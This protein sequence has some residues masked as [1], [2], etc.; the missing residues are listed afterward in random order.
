MTTTRR[1][2]P[3]DPGRR[4]MT[5]A[6]AA[7]EHSA[8]VRDHLISQMEAAGGWLSFERFMDLAL[9]APGLGYYSGGAQKLGEGGDFT[10]APEVSPLFGACVAM[11]CAEVLQ[12]L[13]AGPAAGP[14]AGSVLEIGAGSGRLA[15]D[16]LARLEAQGQLPERYWILEISADLRQ[17]QREHLEKRLPHLLERVHWLDRPPEEHFEGLILANEVLDALPVARF[18][19]RA[20]A[21]DEIGVAMLEKEFAWAARP[22]DTAMAQICH[23]L[24]AAAGGWDDGYV[25]EYCGRVG[26]WTRAVTQSLR[27]GMV[28]WFDY[29]LPRAQYYL[30][31]RHEGTLACHFRHRLSDDPFA[32]VGLQDITAWVD[33]TRVAEASREAGFELAGFTTQAHFLAGL[34][35]DR[36]MRLAAGGD[37]N[38]FARLANQARQLM[39]PGGM[40]ERFKAMAWLRGV[41]LPLSGFSLLDLRHSL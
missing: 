5:P 36:E 16:V 13:G 31:E 27:R 28:L 35:I 41:E 15:A 39:L 38:L 2:I 22:A 11:Q 6:D 7:T 19:W 1:T 40:G 9:Y 32:N 33:F 8:R 30:P 26:A 37:E 12:S 21:V 18:R 25:S 14:G 4:E 23:E 10:T 17:R 20:D 3:Q 24:A 29:G 34:N